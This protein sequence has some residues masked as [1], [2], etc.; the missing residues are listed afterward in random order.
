VNFDDYLHI[1]RG[2]IYYWE[3]YSFKDGGE[4]NKYWVTLNCMV[5]D[6]PINIVLP[7]SQVESHYYTNT[8]NLI[9]TVIIEVGESKYFFKK[10]IIDLKNITHEHQDKIEEAWNDGYLQYKGELEDELFARI[11][12]T[13]RN[14]VTL[15]SMD[16]K[17][18][19]CV[20]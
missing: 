15:S 12:D 3:D 11:E 8:D 9:D 14:A 2:S 5:N 10:T 20:N 4:R 13:I 1:K 7:T 18:Y 16:K 19:L 17:E 6:Y